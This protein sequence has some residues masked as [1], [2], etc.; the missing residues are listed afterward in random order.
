[1]NMTAKHHKTSQVDSVT[2][3]QIFYVFLF[4]IGI[5]IVMA[6]AFGETYEG[7]WYLTGGGSVTGS[8]AKAFITF[9][10][11]FNSFIPIS[12]YIMLEVVK[13]I[14]AFFVNNDILMYHD[15]SD[16]P[17]Q[18]KNSKLNEEFG[19]V[20]YIFS[21]KT[22]TLT[23]N[24][25]EFRC[26]SVTSAEPNSGVITACSYGDIKA[27]PVGSDSPPRKLSATKSKFRDARVQDGAWL[28]E[29]NRDQIRSLLEAMAVCNT[30]VTES[31]KGTVS[32]QASSPDEECLVVGAAS[33]GVRLLTRNET[34][35]QLF[36]IATN[37]ITTWTILKVLEFSSSRKRMSVFCRDPYGR[38]LLIIKG[39]DNVIMSRLK[40][41]MTMAPIHAQT[42]VIL[43]NFASDGLRTLVFARA[44]ISED[45]FTRWRRRYDNV[46]I[47]DNR[48][49]KLE[50]LADEIEK[51]LTLIGT[52]AI[53]DRLQ[54]DVPETIELLGRAGMK[55]WVLTGDKQET[56]LNIAYSCNLLTRDMG[57]F[58]FDFCTPETIEQVLEKFMAD[59][60]SASLE[61][62]QDIG[63]VIQGN[64][65]DH[66]LPHE[67]G[68]HDVNEARADLFVSLAI[69]CKSVLCCRVSPIQKA[70]I[71]EAVKARVLGV[72]L[73][74]GDGANDVSMIQMAHIG[75]G[76]SGV[77][78]L[79]AARSS[80]CAIAQFRYLQRLLLVHG[81]WNYRRIAR[82]ITFTFY[83]NI[84]L[85]LTQMW[86]AM[87]NMFTGQ[88]LYDPWA[89]AMY[90]LAF[91]AMPIMS[92][93][94]FDR[95]VE[96]NR[97][98]SKTQFP[99]LYADGI[100]NRLFNT[101]A[102]WKY[103]LSALFHSIV[104]Y[105]L[106]LYA[107]YDLIESSTGRALGMPGHAMTAYSVI[108]F[109]VTIKCGLEVTTWTLFN[110]LV[111]FLSIYFWY[112]FLFLYCSSY[113]VVQYSDFAMWFGADIITL[114]HPCYWL[115]LFMVIV[116]ALIRD[117]GFKYYRK[118]YDP[119]L[120][121]IV[122][123]FE[124]RQP[125]F[126]RAMVKREAPWLFPKKEKKLFRPTLHQDFFQT[127]DLVGDVMLIPTASELFP[128]F[129]K[130]PGKRHTK[131]SDIIKL[132]IQDPHEM[133]NGRGGSDSNAI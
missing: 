27:P 40:K 66:I 77:E 67:E 17:A 112:L 38:L 30:V 102:F 43:R 132:E 83:K 10:I 64:M 131:I 73:A 124:N 100:K 4:E 34:T 21:D 45:A 39:A 117:I 111:F 118:N 6:I 116:A 89:L 103:G 127:D 13:L 3:H 44:D 24:Q 11:L 109:V 48:E 99:E 58:S 92:L 108:L 79:Q 52:T 35:A 93:A 54:D 9:F 71:V 122:Q 28:N 1:M 119:R 80:D 97:L 2:N 126:D 113:S 105:F 98:L 19:Q 25:M 74:I 69:K 96:A 57:L 85:Y 46:P 88:T 82:L 22:G 47:I 70:M 5:S 130:S 84:T 7:Q 59:V 14:Q 76:I 65:L 42:Q 75:I 29:T 62:G 78:G 55:L 81:R 56:A 63:L 32:Y 31:A 115:I 125:V 36:S 49:A 16:T 106:S 12:L 104:C 50:E 129:E 61:S 133:A 23:C 121:H 120:I 37:S 51:D 33:L 86:F 53:E 60:E 101:A 107:G 91:T 41:D 110:L 26:F 90:N 20:E 68:G 87:Y 95:D 114:G 94:L 18:I 123:E 72:T 128:T 15:D 8:S